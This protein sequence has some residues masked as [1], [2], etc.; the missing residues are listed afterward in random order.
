MVEDTTTIPTTVTTTTV[1][2]PVVVKMGRQSAK[3][4]KKLA[5]GRGRLLDKVMT[6]ISEMQR[7][8]T[9]MSGAQPVIVLV[10]EERRFG[11]FD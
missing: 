3:R 5:K 9:I 1:A 6:A 8:G 2:P 11:L 7:N 4:I 10:K